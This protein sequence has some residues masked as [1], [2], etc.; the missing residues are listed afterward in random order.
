MGTGTGQSSARQGDRMFETRRRSVVKSLV[1]RFIG[2]V[3]TWI[4]AYLII[5]WTP[6]RFQ[7]AAWIAT[8]IVVYHHSTR[9][10]MYYAYERLWSGIR[11]GRLASDAPPP[12]TL[13]TRLL[14]AAGTLLLVAALFFL[15]LYVTPLVKG[16]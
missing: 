5:L 13:R 11:W 8:F 7:K 4:G 1:W 3:W 2:V 16:K 12:L 6:D 10:V 9:M 14:W 15:I